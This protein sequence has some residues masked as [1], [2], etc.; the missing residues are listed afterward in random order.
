MK[1]KKAVLLVCGITLCTIAQS[2]GFSVDKFLNSVVA[3]HPVVMA[4]RADVQ[5]AD[6]ELTGA[7]QQFLPE[8]QATTA[9]P[10]NRE[11]DSVTQPKS[12]VALEQKLWTNGKLTGS[13]EAAEM[14]KKAAQAKLNEA[15]LNIALSAIESL[16]AFR[17]ATERLRVT[18]QTMQ[19]LVRFESM[20]GR[21]VQ[22]GVSA[23][24]D[25]TLVRSRMLQVQ[26]DKSNAEASKR[27]AISRLEQLSLG[28]EVPWRALN[29]KNLGG[30][31]DVRLPQDAAAAWQIIEGTVEQHPSVLRFQA[32]ARVVRARRDVVSADR[33]P[34]V[35]AR[36]EQNRYD[37]P[38]YKTQDGLVTGF[39]GVRF[40]PGAGYAS[41][42]Q[43]RAATERAQGADQ[44]A[45][46]SRREVANQLRQ[47]WEEWR[48]AKERLLD[49]T[50]AVKNSS[51]VSESYER[52]F[53][54]GRLTW[55]QTLDAVREYGQVSLS[56]V[57]T[58][59]SLW[60]SSYR[61]CLRT[62]E[63]ELVDDG[64]AP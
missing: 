10:T 13:L 23:S 63:C 59:A 35:Y 50:S 44:Q 54:V 37:N 14:S 49:Y 36:V 55:Q 33:F 38:N 1:L 8:L 7:W 16:Q 45:E 20:M 30:S 5:A 28:V 15:R 19:R 39:V 43:A 29:I 53:I 24:I 17:S 56:L 52:Q 64:S 60:G 12:T 4:A 25:A 32:E 46:S 41:I 31:L 3:R 34:I 58:E 21:R 61:L 42:A 2:Q 9:R 22:F 48:S 18:E 6:V 27:V 26:V 40:T 47:D 57:D 11:S 62:G 51:F